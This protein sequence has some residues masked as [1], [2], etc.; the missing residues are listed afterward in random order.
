[1]KRLIPMIFVAVSLIG[2]SIEEK[3]ITTPNYQETETVAAVVTPV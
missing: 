3:E 2:C 1:M